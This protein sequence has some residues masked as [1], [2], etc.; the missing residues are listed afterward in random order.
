MS[1]SISPLGQTS[2][3]TVANVAIPSS[4]TAATATYTVTLAQT[5]SIFTLIGAATAALA[6]TLP[7]PGGAPG[8][9]CKFVVNTTLAAFAVT[10]TSPTANSLC[11]SSINNATAAAGVVGTVT[12]FAAST[13]KGAIIDITCDG[14][15][16][17]V[18]GRTVSAAGSILTAAP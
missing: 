2:N 13:A 7:A 3:W 4:T 17:Y 10:I 15:N 1:T 11:I 8:F 14:T 12:G 6:I 9:N 5:G 18:L 16:Y